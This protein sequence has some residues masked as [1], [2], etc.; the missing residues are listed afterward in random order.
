MRRIVTF[1]IG[2]ALDMKLI[3]GD[4]FRV[5]SRA[6]R[7]TYDI[8]PAASLNNFLTGRQRTRHVFIVTV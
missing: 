4:A 5:E 8:F 7:L 2:N 6:T 3:L 1:T